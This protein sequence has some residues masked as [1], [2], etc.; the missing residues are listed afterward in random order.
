MTESWPRSAVDAVLSG[1]LARD[2][3][4]DRLDFKTVG[5]SVSDTLV[6][7]AEATA[8]FANARGGA[9]VVGVADG[10]PG[11]DA[12]VG[13]E[14]DEVRTQ[15]RI[16]E[17]TDPGLIVTVNTVVVDGVR[18]TVIDVPRSPDVHQ[19]KGRATERIGTS[20]EPMSAHRIAAVVSARR[21]D[22]WSDE[23]AEVGPEAVAARAEEELRSRLASA[24]DPERRAWARL[25]LADVLRRLGLLTTQG[26]LTR[27]GEVLLVGRRGYGLR[28]IH[29]RTRSGELTT[30]EVLEGPALVAVTRA[31]ELVEARTDRTPIHLPNGQ[32]L[33]V[34]DLPDIAVREAVVNGVM[35]RD[36]QAQ[37]S[38]QIEHASTRLAVTSPGDFIVGITPQN[39]LTASSR[40]RNASLA[41]AVRALGLA[42]A[43]GV[44]VDRMY[45]AMS[46]IGH[47]PPV[48]ETDGMRVT[49]TLFGGA[50]NAPLTRFVAT[51]DHE[52]QENPDTLLVLVS[53]L[54]ARTVT[55]EGLV[56][57]LQKEA[58]EV[59]TAL[60]HLATDP[61]ALIERTRASASHRR[62]TYR[63]RGEVI[64][65][66]GAAVTYHR[67]S[68]DDSERKIV[69][70]V[71]ETG[72]V[73]SRLVRSILDV[74][75]ATASRM[76]AGLVENGVLVRTSEA[77]RGPSVVYGKG[78]AFPAAERTRR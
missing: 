65:D 1:A 76:I 48:F 33:F 69:D 4:T 70:V 14:L 28:Y 26:T 49:T 36:Y 16:Y 62:G 59:E 43:A 8:C 77:Q 50:P 13:S 34:A 46:A 39:V 29:R 56:P 51:L 11:R 52:R 12:L 3:E 45:A 7:L 22:D 53:L 24:P 58:D 25:E 60:R 64:A 5:R 74:D 15:R 32:Q 67:R 44:G 75:V 19:V 37:G 10:V 66:L 78:P 21:G 31:L 35:H 54:T 17:L 55:A 23:D 2:L 38:V 9:V 71:R 42:E 61:E 6:D 41:N 27:A 63:L 68:R 18:L 57:L 73:N 72:Q 40:T 47:R 20:C 30:N